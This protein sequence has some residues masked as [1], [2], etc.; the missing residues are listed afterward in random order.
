MSR[1]GGK[2]VKE[3]AE[4][5]YRGPELSGLL[6]LFAQEGVDGEDRANKG[7]KLD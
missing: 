6:L 7:Q 2:G 1:P 3:R 5:L 4:E